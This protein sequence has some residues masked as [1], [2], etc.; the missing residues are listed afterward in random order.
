MKPSVV[1]PTA[2][3][4]LI[5][6]AFLLHKAFIFIAN[7]VLDRLYDYR[8]KGSLNTEDPEALVLVPQKDTE[9]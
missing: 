2:L 9:E 7:R 4:K 3:L 8:Q 6:I 5:A 1:D